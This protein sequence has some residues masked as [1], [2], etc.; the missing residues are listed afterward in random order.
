MMQLRKVCN[1]P[2][3]FLNQEEYFPI[4]EQVIRS[5]GTFELLDRMIPK[6]YFYYFC[7]LFLVI[8]C[9]TSVADF[10]IDDACYGYF[11]DVF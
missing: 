1:H 9:E 11:A 5:S 10:F 6:V 8:V 7:D 2:Y 4:T 3:L